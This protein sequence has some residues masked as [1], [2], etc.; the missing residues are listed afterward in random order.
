[1]RRVFLARL[2]IALKSWRP[3]KLYGLLKLGLR[4]L[5]SSK[6]IFL[7]N[8]K[9]T[10]ITL[11]RRSDAAL[12]YSLAVPQPQYQPVLPSM[13]EFHSLRGKLKNLARDVAT[14]EDQPAWAPFIL[15][16]IGKPLACALGVKVKAH[17]P[18]GSVL[19]RSIHQDYG[20]V[21]A[22]VARWVVQ[23]LQHFWGLPHLAKD[24]FAMKSKLEAA[25]SIPYGGAKPSQRQ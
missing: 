18:A 19:P 17:K 9:D 4:L 8:D 10:G 15:K 3:S 13:C 2:G 23:K 20:N 25:N 21:L 16:Y 1:M 24:S 14:V 7:R 11:V 5:K 12:F 6:Y 22:G